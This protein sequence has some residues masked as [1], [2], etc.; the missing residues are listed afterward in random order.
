[1]KKF[2]KYIGLI[3]C[4]SLLVVVYGCSNRSSSSNTKEQTLS[5]VYK[6]PSKADDGTYQPDYWYFKKNGKL[7]YC[8]PQVDSTNKNSDTD[9][10][11]GD[12]SRG[13]WKSLGNDKFEIQ[14]HDVYDNDYYTIKAKLNGDKLHTYSNSKNAKY[15]W[16]ADNST[17]QASMT[18][19]DYMDMFNQ[20]KKSDQ[21]G[22]Q[23]NGYTKPDNDSSSSSS[24]SSD[25]SEMTFDKAAQILEKGD[26][27]DF[28]YDRDSQTHDGS[29]A[30]SNG[31]YFMITYPGAKGQDQY[32]ITKIGKNKYHVK[33]I[34]GSSDGGFTPSPD[35]SS[36]GPTSADVTL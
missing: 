31:G 17:K 14:M 7:L 12:A 6:T 24:S 18:Y 28:D 1:M 21:K 33:A 35:Q 13:T 3:L 29:H 19:S 25:D 26:F 27:S 11:Y 22:I 20:A 23:D 30:T 2:L 16:S 9:F 10:W 34:Y 32:T 36:I 8:T 4:L 5:G 15:S